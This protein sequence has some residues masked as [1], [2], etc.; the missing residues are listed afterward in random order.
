MA[1]SPAHKFGQVIGGLLES[2]VRPP[3]EQFCDKQGLYLDY[4]SKARPARRRRKVSWE[5]PYGNFHDLDFVIERE[6]SDR[7]IGQPVAFI[8][9]AWRR[10]TKHSRNK[11]QEIQGAI[12]PLAEKYRWNNPFLGAVLAGVFTSGSL[13]QLRSLD[14]Q[15]L[16]FPYET[17]VN[18]FA[19]E[20]IDIRFDESTPDEVFR[21]CTDEIAGAPDDL[22]QSIRQHLI[23]A[24]SLQITQFFTALETRLGRTIRRVLVVPL[25]GRINEFVTMEEALRFLE[26]HPIYEGSGEFR[27]YEILVEF[28]NGD[29]VD[30]FFSSKQKVHEF[31]SFVALQ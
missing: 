2:V 31:L 20:G 10:Y 5:D 23:Q 30:A 3:L 26:Q 24:N 13:D 25:Y 9:V 21:K 16:R 4:Q 6:G 18:A 19:S 8:E 29:K 28:S 15:G 27:K 1:E 11:V 12:L 14:F 17:L 22:M 7:E